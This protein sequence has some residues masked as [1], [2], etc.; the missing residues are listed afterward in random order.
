VTE[1]LHSECL[2]AVG[3]CLPVAACAILVGRSLF[4]YLRAGVSRR[5]AAWVLLLAP[6]LMPPLVAGYSYAGFSH[7]VLHRPLLKEIVYGLLLVFRLVPIAVLA[8][9]CMPGGTS[10]EALHCHRLLRPGRPGLGY[11]LTHLRLLL[12]AE[13][14]TGV[15]AGALVFL[16]A[17]GDFELASL[18]SV[19]HWTVALFDAQ[20]GGQSLAESLRLV[21]VP[22]AWSL[23]VLVP[24]LLIL[25]G[26]SVASRSSCDRPAG[27]TARLPL[28]WGYLAL[29]LAGGVLL[30][31]AVVLRGTLEGLLVLLRQF[32]LTRELAAG[33]GVALV[34]AAGAY[35]VVSL[36]VRP[37]RRACRSVCGGLL[38]ATCVPGLMGTLVLALTVQYLFQLPGVRAAYDTPLPL[39]AG[40]VLY[41]L[42]FGILLS[43]VLSDDSLG[44]AG[45]AARLL[46]GSPHADVR[47][48]G[49]A[50]LW[51]LHYRRQFWLFGFLFCLAFFDVTL[52]SILAP[53]GLPS[54]TA[55]LYNFM[56]YGRSAVLSAMVCC[57]VL[58]AVAAVTGLYLAGKEGVRRHG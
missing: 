21:V 5:V 43:C 24:A 31:A 17:F 16:L 22:V 33:L 51:R 1:T 11:W 57:T 48:K 56:H 4:G 10:R 26:R 20:A 9:W 18:L 14:G 36:A 25:K 46:R 54:V 40:L 42:P 58:A 53:T 52:T 49:T 8:W 6:C 50:L 30:P 7:S 3:R 35:L 29:A 55:R 38:V 39:L 45:H 12:G 32:S 47:R 23:A 27:A 34:A 28:V 37:L 41:L 44:T 15:V 2:Q 19:T 13:L